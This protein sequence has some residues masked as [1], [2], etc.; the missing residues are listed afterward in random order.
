MSGGPDPLYVRAC[1]ALLDAADAADLT[2][3]NRSRARGSRRCA[4]IVEGIALGLARFRGRHAIITHRLRQ[5]RRHLDPREQGR[6]DRR[7]VF[8]P[9]EQR[10]RPGLLDVALEQGARIQVEQRHRRFSL[11]MSAMLHPPRRRALGLVFFSRRPL[12]AMGSLSSDAP[13]SGSGTRRA[14]R[15]SPSVRRRVVPRRTSS[16]HL[17]RFAWSS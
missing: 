9:D 7:G 12:Q 11:T 2:D 10:F 13:A 8:D 16:R 4:R 14:T 5:C 15:C 6:S 1:T 17:L 3:L